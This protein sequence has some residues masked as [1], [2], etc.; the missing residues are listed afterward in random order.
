MFAW[1]RKELLQLEIEKALFSL[2]PANILNNLCGEEYSYFNA[3][4]TD[5]I[6]LFP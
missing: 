3:N 1:R 2:V 5:C 6:R 4:E